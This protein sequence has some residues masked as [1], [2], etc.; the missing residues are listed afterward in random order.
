MTKGRFITV[1]GGDGAGK[2]THIPYLK[3]LVEQSGFEVLLTR[4]PGGTELGEKLRDILLK[5]DP[6]PISDD[7][8]LLLMFAARMQHIEE[9]IKPALNKGSWVICDRF[10]DATYAYQA[11]G[12]GIDQ[13][14]IARLEQ[15]VQ[16]G[17]QP[18]L[19][20]LLDLPV[21][22]GMQRVRSRGE[23]G[24]RFEKQKL[25]F[26]SAVR[27]NYLHRANDFSDRIKI[28]DS[29]QSLSRVSDEISKVFSTF[30]TITLQTESL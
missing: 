13:N 21:E 19:T 2:S 30:L 17:L 3:N 25:E 22:T 15:W 10:T 8:E 20:V 29:S 16:R 1:E 24:D 18:D 7:A 5:S 27:R 23:P 11:G 6:I 14:R 26:K 28:V 9:I 4:E 12:R